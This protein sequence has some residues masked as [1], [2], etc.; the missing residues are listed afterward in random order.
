MIMSAETGRGSPVRPQIRGIR[1]WTLWSIDRQGLAFLLIA[2]ALAVLFSIAALRHLQ[3]AGADIG[4]LALLLGL[5]AVYAE[6]TDR[7]ERL[8]CYLATDRGVMASQNAV[9]CF[10]GVLLLPTAGA[11]LLIALVY[12]HMFIRTRRHQAAKPYRLLFVTATV[13]LGGLASSVVFHGLD[14]Q[15]HHVGAVDAAVIVLSL[16]VYT[17]TSLAVL[18]IGM[19]LVA[20]PPSIRLLLPGAHEAAYELSTLLLGVLCGVVVLWTPWLSPLIFVLAAV[21]HR[22]SLVR[23]LQTAATTDDKTGLLNAGAWRELASQQLARCVRANAPTALLL[24]DLDHFKIVNDTHGHLA[25]DAVL[26]LV[27]QA[28]KQE[29]RGHDAVGRYGGEEFAVLLTEVDAPSAADIADRVRA[30]IAAIEPGDGVRVT[31]SIGLAAR[32][33][34]GSLNELLATADT[35]LYRAKAAGRDRVFASR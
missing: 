19:Y 10:A 3:L 30:R 14:G 17:A 4:R 6:A 29:L 28:L 13:L 35:A 32:N 9:V 24:I 15:L 23:Q 21:L 5:G 22:S 12:A 26:A 34:S 25:G 2:D 16:L 7:V 33:A 11:L 27:G 31:A 18:L 8:R 1:R 20:R